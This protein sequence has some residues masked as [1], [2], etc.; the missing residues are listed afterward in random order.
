MKKQY[1]DLI[2]GV[3][4]SLVAVCGIIFM[5]SA[6]TSLTGFISEEERVG[7]TLYD[8]LDPS[9]DVAGAVYALARQG[10][11]KGYDDNTFRPDKKITRAE[12]VKVLLS[13]STFQGSDEDLLFDEFLL[14]N[15]GETVVFD[16]VLID[17]WFAPY[18]YK[19]YTIGVVG[20][21]KDNLFAPYDAISLSEV[22]KILFTLERED[23][24]L[25]G[26]QEAPFTSIPREAWFTSYYIRAKE[27]GLLS[28]NG[29][30]SIDPYRAMTRG[31][32]ALLI[33]GYNNLQTE[34]A[35]K[36]YNSFDILEEER[37]RYLEE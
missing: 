5:W 1:T 4:L 3:V 28:E 8:D 14:K 16:D 19:A 37:G 25:D 17:D 15:K 31:D 13:F 27:L 29:I 24:F 11:M 35:R 26:P 18:I 36:L 30:I 7:V 22:L 6:N 20:G 12:A 2:F 33:S 23:I 10:I 21:K 32:L 9:T 34:R